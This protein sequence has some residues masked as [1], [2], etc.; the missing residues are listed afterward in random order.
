M[1]KTRVTEIL[2]I[3]YPLI[4]GAMYPLT[5]AELVAAV[6]NA[7]GRSKRRRASPINPLVSTSTSSPE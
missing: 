6:G 2:G 7:G 5:K 1:F 4:V 3:E